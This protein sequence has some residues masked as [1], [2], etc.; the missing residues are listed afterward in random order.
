[1]LADNPGMN[2]GHL[3]KAIYDTLYAKC[4]KNNLAADV[5]LS[6]T[7]LSFIDGLVEEYENIG[8]ELFSKVCQDQKN[9]GLLERVALKTENYGNK[10][11]TTYP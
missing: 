4:E 5:S 11:A 9:F 3:G 10:K 8:V 1:M 7:D 2:G 6:L